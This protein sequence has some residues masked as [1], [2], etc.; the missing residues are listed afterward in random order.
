MTL[1][2]GSSLAVSPG[3]PDAGSTQP[4]GAGRLGERERLLA[5]TFEHLE[6]LR[7][8]R[9]QLVL[10]W[11]AVTLVFGAV[12]LTA[13][14]F[15]G[16]LPTG[17]LLAILALLVVSNLAV[18]RALIPRLQRGQWRLGPEA[19][20]KGQ[21][22]VDLSVYTVF[23]HWTGG[24]ENP[25]SVFYVLQV[26]IA[27]VLLSERWAF[28]AA[29]ASSLLCGAVFLLEYTGVLPHVHLT[30]IMDPELYT[31]PAFLLLEWGVLTSALFVAAYLASAIV[32]RMRAR[33]R[34]LF[35]SNLSCE[36]RSGELAQANRRLHEMAVARDTLLRYVTHELRAPVGAIQ[37]YLRLLREGYI[38]PERIPEVALRAEKRAEEVLILIR[39]L[40]DLGQVEQAQ[41]LEGRERVNLADS[42]MEAVDML[43]P[44]AAAKRVSL[45]VDV[46]PG[47]PTVF[48]NPRHLALVWN[49]LISNAI[50]YTPPDGRVLVR[51]QETGEHLLAEVSDTGIG[52]SEEDRERIFGEF[53]RSDSARR[54]DPHGTGLGLTIVQRVV[55][56]YEGE[57]TLDSVEGR[58][59][60]FRVRLPM[61]NLRASCPLPSPQERPGQLPRTLV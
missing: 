34:E 56:M 13:L 53:F 20:I 57:V 51:L 49:N 16:V 8:T 50:K 59:S 52:I 14:V 28:L 25:A 18:M 43:R 31:R 30:G 55:S 39:D 5:S 38:E 23:L 33:E 21:I 46:A 61:Q 3:P 2:G 45:E 7:R 19:L 10:R 36:V 32:Q 58:G 26:I 17:R 29:G 6:L 22:A 27:G 40:L 41:A 47:L 11:V 15:P 1:P 48:T 12:V 37:S 24:A 4:A 9:W 54:F 42:L 35:Q 44:S 60:T